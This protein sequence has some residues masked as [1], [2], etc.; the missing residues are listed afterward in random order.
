M[1]T[2]KEQEKYEV[3]RAKEAEI[4]NRLDLETDPQK[5]AS[6]RA[7]LV[8]ARKAYYRCDDQIYKQLFWDLVLPAQ[9]RVR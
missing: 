1:A 8:A 7:E 5:Q 3:F 4:T 6:I 2:I 9:E